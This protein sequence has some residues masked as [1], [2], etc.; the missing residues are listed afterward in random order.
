M[1]FSYLRD[2]ILVKLIEAFEINGKKLMNRQNYVEIQDLFGQVSTYA[3][4]WHKSNN[5]S[6]SKR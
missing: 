3:I 4:T 2:K 6:V 5:S 1:M